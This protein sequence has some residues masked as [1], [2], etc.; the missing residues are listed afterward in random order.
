[1]VV[2][3][4]AANIYRKQREYQRAKLLYEKAIEI[5]PENSHAWHGKADCLRGM[6]QY[7]Q[8]IKSWEKAMKHGMNPRICLT[9]I[10]DSYI[11]LN[12]FRRAEENY[13]NALSLGY[14]KYAYLGMIKIHVM[15]NELDA[16]SG[17][18]SM[19][20][21]KDPYDDRIADE[22]KRFYNKYPQITGAGP[23]A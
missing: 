9:R 13:R 4:S 10:G 6:R 17:I 23:M 5:D 2:C 12:D 3:T 20:A 8:A 21:E 14:D 16:A 19:L 18:L 22:S 11:N 7:E 1:M 15:R